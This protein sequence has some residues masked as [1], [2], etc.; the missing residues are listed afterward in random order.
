[1][2]ATGGLLIG[3]R[4]VHYGATIILFGEMVFALLISKRP[5]SGP[6]TALGERAGDEAY[7]RFRRVA[8][9]AWALMVISGACWLALVTVQ[10]SGEP[11][12]AIRA[13]AFATVVG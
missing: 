9:A 11:L 3:V 6:G 13:S 8:A 7:R 10:M 2:T 1:M 4:A 5:S 12:G